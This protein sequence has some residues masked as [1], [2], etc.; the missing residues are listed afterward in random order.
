MPTIWSQIALNLSIITACIP[1]LKRVIDAWRS[2]AAAISIAPPYD[3]AVSQ[4]RY[5]TWLDKPINS[6][7]SWINGRS[8]HKGEEGR[9]RREH[10]SPSI[11]LEETQLE[12]RRPRAETMSSR[13]TGDSVARI[14]T[15]EWSGSTTRL[16]ASVT[17]EEWAEYRVRAISTER[18]E[19]TISHKQLPQNTL[20]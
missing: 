11:E 10:Q 17:A 15:A 6:L 12:Q 16:T 7:K 9:Q 5:S 20:G 13:V 8:H 4:N 1:G 18:T 14:G 3:L 19:D 2:D